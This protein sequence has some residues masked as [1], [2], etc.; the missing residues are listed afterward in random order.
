MNELLR[1]VAGWVV[2]VFLGGLALRILWKMWTDEIDLAYLISE[3][4]KDHRG[5]ASL[6]RFQF[7]IFTFVIAAGLLV[8]VFHSKTLP[9][10]D[11]SVLILLGISGGSYVTSKIAQNERKKGANKT[12]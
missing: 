8:I 7:L 4:S 2:V 11:S 12:E 3:S 6:S 5:D 9:K 1:D 10:I